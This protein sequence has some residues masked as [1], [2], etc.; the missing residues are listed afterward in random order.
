[1]K[2]LKLWKD[3][4]KRVEKHNENIDYVNYEET[5]SPCTIFQP[6]FFGIEAAALGFLVSLERECYSLLQPMSAAVFAFVIMFSFMSIA[7]WVNWNANE[8]KKEVV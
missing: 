1:M 3:W 8:T 4:C 7:L 6:L 5:W 2:E